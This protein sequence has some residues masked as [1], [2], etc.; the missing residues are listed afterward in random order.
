MNQAEGQRGARGGEQGYVLA[1]LLG[2]CT[3]MGIF[4]MKAIP[5]DRAELQREQ[6]AELIYRGEHLAKGIRAFQAMTRTYPT[7]LQQLVKHRPR[8]IRQVYKD[9]MTPDGEW[10]Y[11]S[12]VPV[13]P[14]GKTEGLPLVGVKSRSHKDSFR[15]Y[16]QKTIYSDWAFSAVDNL[17]GVPSGTLPAGP[18]GGGGNKGDVATG[19]TDSGGG[20]T[21]PNK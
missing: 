18:Q 11:I 5:A 2:I 21:K 14:G 8:L 3:V 20:S 13:G 16:R 7:T 12:A 1:L 19:P 9:P 15:M 17:L 6:E 10:D 4:M